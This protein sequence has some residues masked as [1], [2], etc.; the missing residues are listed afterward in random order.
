MMLRIS[1][2][3]LLTRKI[4]KGDAGQVLFKPP[5]KRK[6]I[7]YYIYHTEK[8]VLGQKQPEQGR[9]NVRNIRI[10]V[11]KPHGDA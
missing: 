6:S 11:I 2:L 1:L 8:S 10:M 3:S 9:R 7:C 4:L 5:I